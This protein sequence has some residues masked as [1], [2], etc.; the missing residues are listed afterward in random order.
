[1]GLRR[2]LGYPQSLALGRLGQDNH[3][4][5]DSGVSEPYVGAV[6]EAILTI[7]PALTIVDISHDV[8]RSGWSSPRSFFLLSYLSSRRTIY[9]GVVDPGVARNG[10]L[11]LV[12]GTTVFI[13]PTNGVVSLGFETMSCKLHSMDLGRLRW[14]RNSRFLEVA[15][16]GCSASRYFRVGIGDRVFV[17][18]A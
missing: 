7:N 3:A 11:I 4:T 18:P 5:T 9:V 8:A 1:M 6:E 12:R 16:R 13:D 2:R 17:R 14:L 15:M 10:A